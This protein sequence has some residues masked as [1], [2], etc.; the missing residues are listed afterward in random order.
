[1]VLSQK[2]E[3]W[4]I[5]SEDHRIGL[6]IH[7]PFCK[8][9]CNYCDFNSFSGME[10]L[11]PPYF[12]AL[13]RDMELCSEQLGSCSVKSVFI[14]GGTPTFPDAHYVCDILDACAKTFSIE[15]NAEISIEANPGTLSY[16]KLSAY[17]ASGVNR[18]SIG[19]QAYQ[20][21]LLKKLGRIHGAEE[22]SENFNQARR[23]GFSNIN[24]DLIFGIPDQTFDD[25]AQTLSKVIELEP[26]HLSCYSL[27][28]E[29]GTVFGRLYESGEL[30][31]AEDELDR[32][33]Y[34]YA[35]E[36][37]TNHGY[38][39]YEIS[40][41]AKPGMECV[42]NMIYWKAE[43]YLGIGAGSHSY[44]KGKRFNRVYGVKDYISSVEKG[45]IPVE[46]VEKI[47]RDGEISEF[48][49]LGLRLTEG[50]SVS[51]F[52]ERFGQDVYEL[53]GRKLERLAKRQLLDI[54]DD[55]IKLTQTGLDLANQV[56]IE[57]V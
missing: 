18:L 28:I 13:K 11:I 15:K 46:N 14:G 24:V 41:F 5:K 44:L 29:E 27:K 21:H 12:K 45:I 54:K 32:K 1:M 35:I 56:F 30:I 55:R 57:F 36:T 7:I 10:D 40:N 33:M 3:T 53:F 31:P 4:M 42:H 39:H 17:K 43:Q 22:F 16:E 49:I 20:D 50:I 23:A 25:W 8:A 6:Y 47:S 37:L 9:K 51:R 2:G 34:R 38:K 48:M 26:E 52:R 19:L